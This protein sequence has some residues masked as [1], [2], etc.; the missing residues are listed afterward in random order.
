VKSTLT[1]LGNRLAASLARPNG[2]HG[3]P[4]HA[5][6]EPL[7]SDQFEL[8][9]VDAGRFW[10]SRRDQV[11]RPY[12]ARAGT[13]EPEEGRVLRSLVR[14]G[15][16]FLDVGA[17]VGY[18]S[19]L[20]HGMEPGVTVD[21][22][23][24]DPTNVRALRFN[25]WANRINATVW[26][27]ALDD[28]ETALH[29][30]GNTENLGDLRSGRVGEDAASRGSGWIVP[31]IP[32][33]SLFAGRVF[34]LVKLDVQGWE[35]EILLGLNETLRRS[36]AVR[37]V[38][39]FWPAPLRERGREPAEVL[40]RYLEM[41]YALRAVIHGEPAELTLDEIVRVCDS[42]GPDGQVNLLLSR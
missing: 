20:V 28:R 41:G 36:S 11:M 2:S 31:A 14:P 39:E 8:V 5:V 18:F 30:S 19:G 33:D 40:H 3:A 15:C 12:M 26:P 32:G 17:N 38:A 9:L 24:P 16:R 22:V 21:A 37:I 13:W 42:G 35:L 4:A 7:P 23:E 27:L 10:I 6:P 34:D 25:V 1:T 29:L